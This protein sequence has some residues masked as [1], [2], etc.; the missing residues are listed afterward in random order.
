MYIWIVTQ[1][2]VDDLTKTGSSKHR[3]SFG[4]GI[5]NVVVGLLGGMGGNAM[6]AHSLIQVRTGRTHR[7]SNIAWVRV[8]VRA[9]VRAKVRVRVSLSNTAASHVASLQP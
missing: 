2:L 3:E 7:L 8:R 5:G 9:R 4:L 1:E 6:I